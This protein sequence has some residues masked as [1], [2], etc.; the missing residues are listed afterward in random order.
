MATFTLTLHFR[1][2]GGPFGPEKTSQKSYWEG[3]AK[4]LR[5]K[6]ARILNV[7][8][9]LGDVGEPPVTVNVVTITYEAPA[10]IKHERE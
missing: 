7:Q 3:V 6:G 5:E 4:E 1:N 10:E 2:G 8:S 9:R